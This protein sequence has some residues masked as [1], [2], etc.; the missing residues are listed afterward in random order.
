M[1]LVYLTKL[2]V[3]KNQKLQEGY[4]VLADPCGQAKQSLRKV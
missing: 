2:Q 4:N 1:D 3:L